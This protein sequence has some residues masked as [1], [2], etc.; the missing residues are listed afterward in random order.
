MAHQLALP[1][2]TRPALGRA[3]FY[4][5]PANALAVA[6]IDD[7][8]NW[9]AGKL[10]LTGP[11]G[12]GK[13][14]LAGVWARQTGGVVLPAAAL[15]QIDVPGTATGCVCV[16][17]VPDI[18]GQ[19]P[20]EE[21][22]FHLHNLVMSHGHKLLLTAR[23]APSLWPLALPDLKSRVLGAPMV[24]LSEPDDDLLSALIAKLFA[25]RQI[26]P[27]ADVVPY[28]VRHM[29]RSYGAAQRIVDAL[30]AAAL[31]RPKG[32]SRPLAMRLLATVF[33][34]PPQAS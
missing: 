27:A 9:P 11:M 12:A 23:S 4:V 1:L 17:D 24:A 31:G 8:R 28:L 18:A 22:L 13:S 25:D 34:P 2:P 7:W 32:V 21:A 5:A 20:A 26:V 33:D 6:Q 29:P 30:D 14:H 3:D 19:K 16:E 15:S 10:V